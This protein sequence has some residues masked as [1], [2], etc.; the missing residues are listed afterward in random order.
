M[1][2]ATIL[3]VSWNCRNFLMLS[4]MFLPHLT[5]LTMLVKLSS[6]KMMSAASLARAVPHKFIANPTSDFFKAG[7]SLEPSPVTATMYS[8]FLRPVTRRY[9]SSGSDLA[10]TARCVMI[11]SKASL[12]LTIGLPFSSSTKPPTASLNSLPSSTAFD[13]SDFSSRRWHCLAIFIAV[14]LLSPVT[15]ITLR[16]ALCTVSTALGTSGLI[17]SSSPTSPTKIRFSSS[18][19]L[20]TC[21]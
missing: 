5:A 20:T 14:S 6:S 21:S 18:L 13:V 2:K 10:S 4:K 7:A 19:G 9:L 8:R 3:I 11:A 17:G 15:M 1:T 12:F 16:P